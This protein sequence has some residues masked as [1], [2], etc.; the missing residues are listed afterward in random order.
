MLDAVVAAIRAKAPPG[1]IS[2]KVVAV[3]GPG[4]AGKSTL[5]ERLAQSLGGAQIV[6][7]DDFASWSIPL[8]WWPR[9]VEEVLEPLAR[10]ERSRYR[11]STWST[12]QPED[13]KEVAPAEF[14]VL[15]GVSASR[16][17]FRPYL[18]YSIWIETPRDVRLQRG[19]ARDGEE[20]RGQWEQWMAE[21]D[22]Y[23][24]R[25]RPHERADAVLPG[26]GDVPTR[27][28]SSVR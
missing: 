8:D 10:G 1:G 21:E 3:D 17:A 24:A 7:T 27:G 26:Y 13:W 12:E 20:A 11:C 15:E 14:V 9:L 5:A 25:E 4:G 19:L 6:R 16:A 28:R 23:V 18:T 2:T 22:A